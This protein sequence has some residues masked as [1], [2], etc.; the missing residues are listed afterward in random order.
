MWKNTVEVDRPLITIWRMRFACWLPE[1]PN[2]NSENVI[3]IAFPLQRMLQE[4]VS[5]LGYTYIARLTQPDNDLIL[6]RNM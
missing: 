1:A 4:R 2:R 6:S 3:L 5:M